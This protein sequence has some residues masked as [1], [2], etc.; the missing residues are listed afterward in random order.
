MKRLRAALAAPLVIWATPDHWLGRR[1]GMSQ[2]LLTPKSGA[3]GEGELSVLAPSH[4]HADT[5]RS[6]VALKAISGL[7]SDW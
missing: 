4:E 5:Y 3:E 7:R 6:W 2:I 1:H